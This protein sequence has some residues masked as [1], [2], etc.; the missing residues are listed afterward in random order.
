VIFGLAQPLPIVYFSLQCFFAR[1]DT[2]IITA[3]CRAR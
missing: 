3:S 1:I 2:I